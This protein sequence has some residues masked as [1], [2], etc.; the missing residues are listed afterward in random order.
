MKI[1]N[2]VLSFI[3][4]NTCMAGIVLYLLDYEDAAIIL[5][6]V[7]MASFAIMLLFYVYKLYAVVNLKKNNPE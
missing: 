6:I 1:I 5:V 7:S 4:L 2:G 3:G